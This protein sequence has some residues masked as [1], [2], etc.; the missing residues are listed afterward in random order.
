[1]SIVAS[2]LGSLLDMNHVM[3]EIAVEGPATNTPIGVTVNEYGRR[4]L[5]EVS[6]KVNG[7]SRFAHPTLIRGNRD[8]H[9]K[10][11]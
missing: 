8:N 5:L 6:S 1:V 11:V 4:F 9:S 10:G 7:G 2:E 3:G